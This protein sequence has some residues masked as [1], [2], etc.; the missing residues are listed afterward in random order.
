MEAGV[1]KFE[2][3][4]FCKYFE[5]EYKLNEAQCAL[6]RNRFDTVGE[7][8]QFVEEHNSED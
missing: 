3:E 5:E 7:V 8:E 1:Q 4:V 6:V 2:E